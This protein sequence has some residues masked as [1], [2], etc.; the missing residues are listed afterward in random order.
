MTH[1]HKEARKRVGHLEGGRSQGP[2]RLVALVLVA[3]DPVLAGVPTLHV[4]TSRATA[5]P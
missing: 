3:S 1:L 4:G 5:S 2:L